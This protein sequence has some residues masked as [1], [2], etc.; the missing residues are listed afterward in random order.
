MTAS[1]VGVKK[2]GGRKKG[3][4]DGGHGKGGGGG[5]GINAMR[6]GLEVTEIFSCVDSNSSR[7]ADSKSSI[8]T[9]GRGEDGEEEDVV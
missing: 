2:R 8:N 3:Q 1:E 6:A 7:I 9:P 4:M 5:D